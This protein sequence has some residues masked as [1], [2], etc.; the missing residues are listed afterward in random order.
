MLKAKAP[1][2]AGDLTYL[3]KRNLDSSMTCS[4]GI[5]HQKNTC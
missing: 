1:F 3:L 5:T 4:P 2:K